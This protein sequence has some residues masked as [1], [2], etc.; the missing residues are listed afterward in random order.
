MS[1]CESIDTLSMAYLDD[2]LAAEERRELE[3]HLTEC[4][5]CRSHLDGERSEHALLHRALAA[6]PAPALLRA[7]L[8]RA[9]DAEDQAAARAARKRWTRFVLPGSAIAAAAAAMAMFVGGQIPSE[10]GAAVVDQVV[11][12]Q[13]RPLPMEVQGPSTGSWLR[14]NFAS[15][16]LPQVQAPTS[17]Q[18]GARLLPGGVNGHDAALVQWQIDLGRG[19]FVLSMVAIQDVRDGELEGGEEQEINGRTVHVVE[20]GGRFAVTFIDANHIG[21]AFMAP[22]LSPRELVALVGRIHLQ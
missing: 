22:E 16:E 18:L 19:P 10:R 14:Q 2:E 21:Y 15:M 9:L 13:I 7:R 11:R 8:A 3:L 1:L 17:Q 6:P 12:Q 4:P 20:D 5:G